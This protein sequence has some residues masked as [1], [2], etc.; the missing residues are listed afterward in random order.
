MNL[1]HSQSHIVWTVSLLNFLC[2]DISAWDVVFI[3]LLVS[4]FCVVLAVT[5]M[6]ELVSMSALLL[7]P[8]GKLRLHQTACI[9]AYVWSNYSVEVWGTCHVVCQS[10]ESTVCHSTPT[11]THSMVC[12]DCQTITPFA[13]FVYIECYTHMVFACCYTQTLCWTYFHHQASLQ[14]V[15]RGVPCVIC[16]LP[17]SRFASKSCGATEAKALAKRRHSKCRSLNN[18]EGI[19][20]KKPLTGPP[21]RSF[22]I[23]VS[24][25]S[26]IPW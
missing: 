2:F 3:L 16:P 9:C 17:N 18:D 19:Q 22:V 26:E 23:R 6:P 8:A 21:G 15:Y 24:R 11:M 10:Q 7:Y 12:Y 1:A 14:C 13:L 5:T 4:L 25:M 20:H